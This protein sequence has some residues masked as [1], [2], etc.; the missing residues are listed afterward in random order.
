[1]TLVVATSRGVPQMKLTTIAATAALALTMAP[2]PS[3]AFFL[4]EKAVD[5]KLHII[6]CFGLLLSERHAAECGGTVTGPFNTISSPGSPSG[7]AA[8]PVSTTPEGPEN[9]WPKGDYG[10]KHSFPSQSSR[11]FGRGRD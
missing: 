11:H 6:E 3:Q 7:P 10:Y 1:M 8:M 5:Y 9:C 2:L 4:N